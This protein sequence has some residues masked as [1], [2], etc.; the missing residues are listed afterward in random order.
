[1]PQDYFGERVAERYDQSEADMFEPASQT[2]NLRVE[3]ILATLAK[4]ILTAWHKRMSLH[5]TQ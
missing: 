2:S 3:N 5:F 4:L 1:M